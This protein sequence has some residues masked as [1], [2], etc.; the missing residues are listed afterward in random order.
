[1]STENQTPLWISRLLLNPRKKEV[2]RDLADPYAMHRTLSRA[3]SR[4]L[5]EGKERLLWRLE[6]V[7]PHEHPVLLVQSLTKP[8]WERVLEE[9]PGYA[10]VFPP[11][12]F[13]PDLREGQRFFFRLRANPSFREKQTRRRKA[14]KT[15]EEK[16]DWLKRRLEAGGYGLL[17]AIILR[18]EFVEGRKGGSKIQVQATLF[19]GRLEVIDP[20]KALKT[21][22]M[23]IGPGK[24]L[25]L[26]LLSLHP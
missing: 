10:E 2:R 22:S 12:P 9:F 6:P 25:G 4:G 7:R 14:L 13:R 20:E 16:R 15:E 19:E 23:G 8:E 1:M 21:L 18:D 11:K 26:G 17:E 3:V 24:A 5:E